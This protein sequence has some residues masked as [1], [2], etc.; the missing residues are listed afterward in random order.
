MPTAQ[1]TRLHGA[2]LHAAPAPSATPLENA[3][4]RPDVPAAL[5]SGTRDLTAPF[6]LHD[7]FAEEFRQGMSP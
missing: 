5:Q 7:V 2:F 4:Q 6:I 1:E 3:G